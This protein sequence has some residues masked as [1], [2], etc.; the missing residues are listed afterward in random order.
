MR[1]AEAYHAAGAD[2]ILIHSARSTPDEVLAFKAEWGNR[3]PVI[4]VPTKY[5]ATPTSVF[6]EAGFSVVIWANQIL[7]ASIRAM[8][9]TAARIHADRSLIGVEDAIVPIG[10]IFRL[11]G[12]D[13]LEVEAGRYLPRTA[14]MAQAII[15]AASRGAELG[16]LTIDM[17]QA[18]RERTNEFAVLKTLGF[19]DGRIFGLVLAESCLIAVVGGG[20]G[21]GL[22]AAAIALVGDPTN[23]MLP[24]I[25][26][27][28]RDAAGGCGV[29]ALLGVATGVLPALQAQRL[30]IVDALRRT[31]MLMQILAVTAM[32]LRSLPQRLGSAAV[33]VFGIVGVVMVFVAVLSIA[34]GLRGLEAAG[35]PD[36]ALVLRAGSDTEL[37]SGFYLEHVRAIAE[38]PGVAHDGAEALASPELLVIVDVPLRRNGIEAQ[39][40]LRGV[41]P[42]AFKVHDRLRIV[43]GRNFTPGRN[44]IIV[45]R[46]ALRQY[47]GLDVGSTVRSGQNIWRVVGIFEDGDSVAKARSGAMRGW[48]IPCTTATIRTSR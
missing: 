18:T 29:I 28:T 30:R 23:G 6:E 36:T 33:A 12:E 42:V 2:G 45:G 48:P 40:P 1:R 43:A 44:E 47:A 39:V 9:E 10:E 38:A 37:T 7:R 16:E 3:T 13:E 5:Y 46:A 32:N 24:P 11:Q 27:T 25:H 14:A 15:L 4:I 34:E 8:R 20:A 17:A 26:L 19:G 41:L 31:L 35:D 21:L 22:S